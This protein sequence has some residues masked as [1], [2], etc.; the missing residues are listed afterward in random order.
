MKET[1]N[2]GKI[3]YFLSIDQSIKSYIFREFYYI[4]AIIQFFFLGL[5]YNLY[6]NI[7]YIISLIDRVF[8]NKTHSTIK[9]K[10]IS[11]LITIKEINSNKHEVSEYIRIKIYFSNKNKIT[12]LIKREFYIIDN[13]TTKTLIKINIIKSKDIIL[14]L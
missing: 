9:V 10:K 5:L 13:L 4:I 3:I 14:D 11:T 1:N 12:I 7:K 6:F 8:L 2:F